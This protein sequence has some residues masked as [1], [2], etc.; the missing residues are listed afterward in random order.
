VIGL[1]A[2]SMAPFA[3]WHLATYDALRFTLYIVLQNDDF[4]IMAFNLYQRGAK[5]KQ[6]VL[7]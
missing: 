6:L 2:K 5:V 7:L 4:S 3:K 1:S